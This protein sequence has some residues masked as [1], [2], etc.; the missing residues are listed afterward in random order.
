M[1]ELWTRED[2][3][4]NVW[5][6]ADEYDTGDTPCVRGDGRCEDCPCYAECFEER[7]EED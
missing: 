6:H 3:N 1:E 7:K 5:A 2:R 4:Y